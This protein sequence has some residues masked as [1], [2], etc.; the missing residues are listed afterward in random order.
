MVAP[1]LLIVCRFGRLAARFPWVG[2]CKNAILIERRVRITHHQL[3]AQGNQSDL[4]W[5]QLELSR[6]PHKR[7]LQLIVIQPGTNRG[8]G[9]STAAHVYHSPPELLREG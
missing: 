4:P 1:L 2:R 5:F 6:T 3:S 9:N 7:L 8:V